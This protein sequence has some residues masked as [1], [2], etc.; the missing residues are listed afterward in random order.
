MK[1]ILCLFH[2][3]PFVPSK[4]SS[5]IPSVLNLK[6]AFFV[7]SRMLNWTVTQLSSWL[8]DDQVDVSQ[9]SINWLRWVGFLRNNI[10]KLYPFLL[11]LGTIN[12]YRWSSNYHF[13]ADSSALRFAS[14][15]ANEPKSTLLT[16]PIGVKAW[17]K[18]IPVSAGASTRF[19][20]GGRTEGKRVMDVGERIQDVSHLLAV[21]PNLGS[22]FPSRQGQA[23]NRSS[24]AHSVTYTK[25]HVC[26]HVY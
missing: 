6:V 25:D 13:R 2:S 4:M 11:S 12:K 26:T 17:S 10:N 16:L 22:L 20:Y 18:Q 9:E 5:C 21:L 3:T 7:K 24:L 14:L 23:H 15:L 8:I 19:L 1:H